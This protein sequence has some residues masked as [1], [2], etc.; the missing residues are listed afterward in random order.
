VQNSLT[1]S[2]FWSCAGGGH[3]MQLRTTEQAAKKI[4]FVRS[5]LTLQLGYQKIKD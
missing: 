2:R 3:S 4:F 5:S 1:F